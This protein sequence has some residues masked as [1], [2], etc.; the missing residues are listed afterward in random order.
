MNDHF[1][2]L[3]EVESLQDFQQNHQEYQKY[4][5]C[6]FTEEEMNSPCTIYELKILYFLILWLYWGIMIAA[7]YAS[8]VCLGLNKSCVPHEMEVSIP[9]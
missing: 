3:H 9:I 2:Q 7:R 6:N 4:F 1:Q 5:F 8:L